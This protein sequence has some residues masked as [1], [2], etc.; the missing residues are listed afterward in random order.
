MEGG[1][2]QLRLETVAPSVDPY[3]SN[4]G[5]VNRKGED[6]DGKVLGPTHQPAE[7]ASRRAASR[8]RRAARDLGL[9][10]VRRSLEERCR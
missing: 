6:A 7:R 2:H 5:G 4:G 1:D 3:G 8:S 9:E 10:L